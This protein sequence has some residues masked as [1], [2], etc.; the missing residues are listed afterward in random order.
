[1][2]KS[3]NILLFCTDSLRCDALRFM[4]NE[5]ALSPNA[6]RLAKEGVFFTQA[7][8]SSPVCSP[9]RSSLITGL[10][11]PVHGCLENGMERH[12]DL[13]TLPEKLKQ[14][15]YHT[16]MAGKQHFGKC[17]EFDSIV[18][19]S[20]EELEE[21]GKASKYPD[22]RVFSKRESIIRD[23]VV[24][25]RCIEEM[26]KAKEEG[27]PFFAFCSINAPHAPLEP[28]QE[29]MEAVA[30]FPLPTLNL[31][32]GEENN[33]PPHQKN[34]IGLS[35]EEQLI[36][37]LAKENPEYWIEAVGRVYD[38]DHERT[39]NEW[40]RRFYALAYYA[41]V[42]LGRILDYLDSS[43]LANDT[44]VIFTSDHGQQYFDHGFNDKH[45][46]YDESWRIPLVLRHPGKLKEGETREF[47]CWTDLTATIVA[48]A[49]IEWDDVQG[50][51]LYHPLIEGEPSPRGC[52]I[53]TLFKSCALATTRW[54][55]EYYLD[56]RQGR[57]FDRLLDPEEQNDIW[58][59]ANH[60]KIRDS[61]LAALLAWRSDLEATASHRSRILEKNPGAYSDREI[62]S[63]RVNRQVK[64]WKGADSENRLNSDVGKILEAYAKSAMDQEIVT[65]L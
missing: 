59:S 50:F 21:L 8:T 5:N 60:R 37:G 64:K 13:D 26:D 4:G 10:H 24:V 65:A 38:P 27:T 12:S 29:A 15:G 23:A 52:A 46:W 35:G 32:P 42:L 54:K 51:D 6:D 11:A 2:S 30:D 14:A 62:V 1:M 36:D 17:P 9:A 48:A 45:C 22:D 44:L 20:K 56:D 57:F 19:P 39:I 43:G 53:G 41:D 3:P 49:G 28:S 40:R 25:D 47:A 58:N 61:L 55:I 7:H 34:L 16:I 33:L 18:S 63:D 31:K